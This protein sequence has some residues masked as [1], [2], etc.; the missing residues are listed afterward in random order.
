M[1]YLF[2]VSHLVLRKKGDKNRTQKKEKSLILIE[3]DENAS[4]RPL[5]EN[6]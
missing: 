1:R 4:A 6:E 3:I 2:Q 5:N